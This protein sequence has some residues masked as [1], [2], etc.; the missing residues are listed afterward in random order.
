MARECLETWTESDLVD[1]VRAGSGEGFAELYRR[2]APATRMAVGDY[3]DDPEQ[4][5]DVVQEVFTRAL[6]RL[7]SLRDTSRF[8]PW[9]LQIAR[10]A[11]IDD[12]RQRRSARMESID[13]DDDSLFRSRDP[14]PDVEAEVRELAAAVSAGVASVSARDAAVL[15]MTV[16]LGFGPAEIASALG[17]SD[18]NAKVILHRARRRLRRALEQQDLLESHD[19]SKTAAAQ[20]PT[21]RMSES[22]T[23]A[24][25]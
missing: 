23:N 19:R 7:D 5:L 21:T 1:A 24:A 8:R 6:A 11:A 17:I 9:V 25:K 12:L 16:Q 3:V 4:Q 18:G 15:S 13:V 2:H 10:N 20:N 14:G 22:R